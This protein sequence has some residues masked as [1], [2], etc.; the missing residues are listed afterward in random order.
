MMPLQDL[1]RSNRHVGHY[2]GEDSTPRSGPGESAAYT[3]TGSL[4]LVY[5]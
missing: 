4:D 5:T 3:S 1:R 2:S